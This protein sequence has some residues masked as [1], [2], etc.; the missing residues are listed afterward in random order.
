MG[1]R[2]TSVSADCV[3]FMPTFSPYDPTHSSV[4]KTNI[5]RPNVAS[6]LNTRVPTKRGGA[7]PLMMLQW[8]EKPK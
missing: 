6:H 4:K 8:V 5:S 1:H 3:N 7:C 2:I